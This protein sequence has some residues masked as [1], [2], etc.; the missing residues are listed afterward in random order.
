M[1]SARR[2]G[3]LNTNGRRDRRGANGTGSR[4]EERNEDRERSE[5][6]KALRTLLQR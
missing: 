5:A 1:V 2:C 4:M 3:V 6:T